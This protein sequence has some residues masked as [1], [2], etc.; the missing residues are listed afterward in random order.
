MKPN[1]EDLLEL[2]NITSITDNQ[3]DCINS[4]AITSL[5]TVYALGLHFNNDRCTMD[6]LQFFCNATL[7]LCNEDEPFDL[8]SMCLDVRD[9]KCALEWRMVETLLNISVPDCTSFGV[10]RS[11]KFSKAPL[12]NCPDQFG[13]FCDSICLPVCGEYNPYRKRAVHA[14]YIFVFV[15]ATIGWIGGLV[16]LI[17]CCYN[18]RKL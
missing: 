7:S 14:Y 3:Q 5:H 6:A 11:L 13:I 1:T 15:C 4:S 16:T 12:P 8:T 18:R 10:N 9:N 17:G 2:C